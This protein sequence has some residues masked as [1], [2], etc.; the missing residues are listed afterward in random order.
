MYLRPGL[1]KQQTRATD[2]P[3]RR[4]RLLLQR[5]SKA[6]LV[7]VWLVKIT[8]DGPLGL[9]AARTLLADRPLQAAYREHEDDRRRALVAHAAL[10]RL[11]ARR[12]GT[13]PASVDI[14]RDERG[15]PV[16]PAA[17]R[18]H[19][20]VSHSGNYVACAVSSLPVGVD[21]ERTDRSEVDEAFASRV[22]VPGELAQLGR[23]PSDA[24]ASA[25]I[26]MWTRKEAVAKALGVG[27]ALPFDQLTITG[28]RPLVNGVRVPSMWIRDVERSP[29]GYA[30]AVAGEG[31]RAALRGYLFV[32]GAVSRLA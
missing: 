28:A 2:F 8:V 11:V 21:L 16:L 1:A 5:V 24:R 3:G 12:M 10:A 20:S 30:I 19:A 27:H 9:N 15:R 22:C 7:D 14:R 4:L 23:A 17:S 31:G 26:R 29:P 25:L 18:L 32:G 6:T 13:D